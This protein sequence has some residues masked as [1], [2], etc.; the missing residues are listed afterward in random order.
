MQTYETQI[1]IQQEGKK[2]ARIG[3]LE[4]KAASEQE[5]LDIAKA[6]GQKSYDRACAVMGHRNETTRI[7]AELY[8][9][10]DAA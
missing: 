5:A 7:W 10:E 8:K 4:V 2:P 6:E 9:E 3:R 1:M